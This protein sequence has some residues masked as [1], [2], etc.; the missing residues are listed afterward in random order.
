MQG[1]LTITKFMPNHNQASLE[2][3]DSIGRPSRSIFN[4]P[5]LSLASLMS[6]SSAD[7]PFVASWTVLGCAPTAVIVSEGRSLSEDHALRIAWL[8]ELRERARQ[9]GSPLPPLPVDLELCLREHRMNRI[10]WV[11]PM[12]LW[13]TRIFR[14]VVWLAPV[15]RVFRKLGGMVRY[16]YRHT[17]KWLRARRAWLGRW[18]KPTRRP[19]VLDELTTEELALFDRL[20]VARTEYLGQ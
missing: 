14:T 15:D 19:G 2:A 7:F 20:V 12:L 17:R 11:G 10:V 5:A 6:V 13:L 4:R 9:A 16:T 18:M 1:T 3:G 8:S